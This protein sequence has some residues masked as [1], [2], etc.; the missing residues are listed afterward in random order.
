MLRKKAQQLARFHSSTCIVP[1][2]EMKLQFLY[3][4]RGQKG[5]LGVGRTNSVLSSVASEIDLEFRMC[6]FYCFVSD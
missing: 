4:K 6:S 2:S 5:G 1:L 3:K